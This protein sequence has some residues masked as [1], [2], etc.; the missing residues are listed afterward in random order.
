MAK[1]SEEER[2]DIKMWG[3]AT[4]LGVPWIKTKTGALIF[5][6]A[7]TLH[8]MQELIACYAMP[9]VVVEVSGGVAEVTHC[10]DWVDCEII[11]HDNIEA[12]DDAPTCSHAD[13]NVPGTRI[14]QGRGWTCGNHEGDK[15]EIPDD[16]G[17]AEVAEFMATPPKPQK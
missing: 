3:I 1:I 11:D 10:P 16:I 5:D 7:R 2:R 13:C 9:Q 6:E 15:P 8:K 14:V 17:V 4:V 12:G